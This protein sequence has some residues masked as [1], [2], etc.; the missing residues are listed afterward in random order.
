MESL[1][2]KIAQSGVGLLFDVS[3]IILPANMAFNKASDKPDLE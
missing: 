3:Q 2:I 1:F